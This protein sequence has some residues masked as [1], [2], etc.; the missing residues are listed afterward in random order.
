MEKGKKELKDK[1]EGEL[2]LQDQVSN[3]P[4]LKADAVCLEIENLEK[5]SVNT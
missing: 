1:R 3:V 5:Q 4:D 2:R